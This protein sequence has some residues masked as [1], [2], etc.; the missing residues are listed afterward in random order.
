MSVRVC[1]LHVTLADR[2]SF[3]IELLQDSMLGLWV[4]QDLVSVNV[5]SHLLLLLLTQLSI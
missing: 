2:A 4:S 5:Q 1:V 3:L